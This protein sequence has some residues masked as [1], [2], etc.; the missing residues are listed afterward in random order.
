MSALGQMTPSVTWTNVDLLLYVFC[1][2]HSMAILL[3][4]PMNL[5]R[6]MCPEVIQKPFH[7]SEAPM[8]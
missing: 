2:T 1:G 3:E 4:G 7:I 5:I 8:T 6:N